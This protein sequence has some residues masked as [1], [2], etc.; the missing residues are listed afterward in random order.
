MNDS[1]PLPIRVLDDMLKVLLG[2]IVSKEGLGITDFGII[3]ID[4]DGTIMKNDTLKSTYNGADKFKKSLN[5][6]D[7]K[8]IEFLE[9]PEFAEYRAMQRPTHPKCINCPE[10]N[11]CGGG[12]ILHRWS[13]E[14]GFDNPSVFCADQLYLIGD[15][16]KELAQFNLEHAWF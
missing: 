4:T 14:N 15:M 10:L 12:M 8:L 7:G 9:S 16:R 13:K 11:I 5:I 6:K 2:G 3:I 1:D